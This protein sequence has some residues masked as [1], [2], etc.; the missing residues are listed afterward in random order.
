MLD[1]TGIEGGV[2][3]PLEEATEDEGK[4]LSTVCSSSKSSQPSGRR[5]LTNQGKPS[6]STPQ[7]QEPIPN[8]PSKKAMSTAESVEGISILLGWH[9]KSCAP[10]FYDAH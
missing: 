8:A 7:T 6:R 4:L 1:F 10:Y 5:P 2:L 9:N 3:A